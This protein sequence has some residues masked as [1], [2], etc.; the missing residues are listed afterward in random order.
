M[1]IEAMVVFSHKAEGTRQRS[2]EHFGIRGGNS[3]PFSSG[4]RVHALKY[5]VRLA[6]DRAQALLTSAPLM[7]TRVESSSP[8]RNSGPLSPGS[9]KAAHI[10]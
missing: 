2:G 1:L 4:G 7:N 9:P 3:G 5:Q 10:Q 8:H 6:G